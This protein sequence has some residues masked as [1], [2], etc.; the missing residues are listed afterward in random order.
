M[1]M[2]SFELVSDHNWSY[3]DAE[4]GHVKESMIWGA[5][6]CSTDGDDYFWSVLSLMQTWSVIAN[7][8]QRPIPSSVR[9]SIQ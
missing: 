5:K 8:F 4:G 6:K 3:F 1:Y 7:A 9:P 2:K